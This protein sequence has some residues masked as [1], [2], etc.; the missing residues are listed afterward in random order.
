MLP[1][2]EAIAYVDSQMSGVSQKQ[3]EFA[4]EILALIDQTNNASTGTE[5]ESSN[6]TSDREPTLL[7]IIT[8]DIRTNKVVVYSKSHCPFCKQTKNLLSKAGIDAKI[9]EL[10]QLS[11]GREIQTTLKSMTSQATVPNIFIGGKHIGGNSDLQALGV[12]K[13]KEMIN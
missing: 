3:R 4:D 7:E 1:K 5:P 11:N 13:I 8:N 9:F 10:D 6:A 2:E 12:D